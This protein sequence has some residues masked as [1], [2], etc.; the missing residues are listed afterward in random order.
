M[1]NVFILHRRLIIVFEYNKSRAVNNHSFYV[2]RYLPLALSIAIYQYLVYIRPFMDFLYNQFGLAHLRSNPEFLFQD[3]SRKKKHLSSLQATDILRRMTAAFPSPMA[4]ALYRQ[5][6]LAIAK[7]YI[8]K[9]VERTDFYEPSSALE[10]KSMLAIGAGHS[11]RMLLTSYAIDHAYPTRLQPE[12]LE[13][14][15]HLSTLWQQ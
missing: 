9:L 14:Y 10:P 7:R 4:L 1:R 11:T 8:S 5:A 15:L 6:S 12:L 13:L 3:P 2:I